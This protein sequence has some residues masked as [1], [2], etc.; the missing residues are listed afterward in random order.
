[1]FCFSVG[2]DA[3]DARGPKCFSCGLM[4]ASCDGYARL[5]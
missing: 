1:M 2:S 5:P 4:M 3:T